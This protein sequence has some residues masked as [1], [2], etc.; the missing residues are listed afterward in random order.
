MPTPLDPIV[1]EFATVEE[2]EA[3]D[4]WFRE[5]VRRSMADT[6][7]RIPHAQ[8]MAEMEEIISEAEKR[9]RSRAA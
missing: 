8:V 5:K 4:Q 1:S 6:R 9:H 3:Y 2:A 7:P